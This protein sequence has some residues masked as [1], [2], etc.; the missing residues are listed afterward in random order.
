MTAAITHPL[1]CSE[2][3]SRRLRLE[4]E[5]GQAPALL[6]AVVL[7]SLLILVAGM[8]PR[9]AEVGESP[10]ALDPGIELVN[11]PG[12]GAPMRSG[13]ERNVSPSN[14]HATVQPVQ[15]GIAPRSTPFETGTAAGVDDGDP[16]LTPSTV[17][18]DAGGGHADAGSL[19]LLE[20]G[21]PVFVDE[22]PS[23]QK[24]FTPDYPALARDAAVEGKVVLWVLVGTDGA[25]QEV[26]VH[27][28]I[29][30]L[31]EA[32]R[33]AVER[34]R[35]KPAFSNGHAVRVWVAVPVSFRLHD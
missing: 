20:P 16:A 35:F 18:R 12:L 30:M 26:R 11:E 25:V 7:V 28:S 34:W 32:A 15:D 1:L 10:G 3:P 4:S 17:T 5:G 29:P 23:V 13:I 27:R 22:M 21:V 31:D 14:D 9:P 2:L 33:D 6:C 19:E 24:T 8:I